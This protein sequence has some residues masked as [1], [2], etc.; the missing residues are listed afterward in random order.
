MPYRIN[1]RRNEL[2]L[3]SRQMV[4]KK[5]NGMNGNRLSQ[6]KRYILSLLPVKLTIITNNY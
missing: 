2:V 4:L 5:N 1:L 3:Q 6:A